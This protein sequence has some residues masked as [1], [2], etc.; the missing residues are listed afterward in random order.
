MFVSRETVRS[1]QKIFLG[2]SLL[3]VSYLMFL[4]SDFSF[5]FHSK[6]LGVYIMS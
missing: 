4:V 2:V 3:W 6:E 5:F 1:S